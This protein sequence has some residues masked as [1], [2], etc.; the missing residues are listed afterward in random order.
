MTAVAV[1]AATMA[2]IG[3]LDSVADQGAAGEIA[4]AGWKTALGGIGLYLNV[5][6]FSSDGSQ[7]KSESFLYAYLGSMVAVG[8]A[9]V[10]LNKK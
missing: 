9:A 5:L 8:A 1:G 4:R 6:A 10:L 3:A 2:V 7:F